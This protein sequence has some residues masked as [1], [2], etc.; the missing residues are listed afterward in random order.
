VR[1]LPAL[2]AAAFGA[3]VLISAFFLLSATRSIANNLP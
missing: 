2:L 1:L 3:I